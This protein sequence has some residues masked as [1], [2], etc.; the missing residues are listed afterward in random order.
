MTLHAPRARAVASQGATSR[1]A[2]LNGGPG[3][4]RDSGH[5]LGVLGG[6]A[7]LSLDAL[8]SV[9]YGPQAMIVILVL[10]GGSALRWTVPL[11]IVI[12]A[13]LVIL[14]FS[15]TQVIS[16]HPEGGGAYAVAKANLGRPA[17]LLAAA[18]LVVD[19]VLTVAVSLAVGAASLASVFPALA[20][21]LLL[22]SLVALVILTTVNMFGIAASAKL[23]IVPGALFVIS[24]L[25]VL[26]VAPFHSKPV[27]VIGTYPGPIVATKTVG[28]LLLLKAFANGC[29]A[30]TGVE[31]IANGVPA[32]RRPRVR[33]A[34]RTELALGVLLGVMLIGLAVLIRA[35][36][37]VPRGNV[38]ILAQLTAGTFG[39][40]AVFYVCNL[41]VALALGLAANT[42]F[43]GLP[44]LM[45]LLAKDNR[46]PH[47]FYLR[48][49]RPIYRY[50]I[51]TLAL[52]AALLLVVVDAQTERLIPLFTI[53][54]FIGFTISQL[55]LVRLWLSARPSRWR[56][57]GDQRPRGDTD[58]D[59]SR[60]GA[61]D[62]V[63]GRRVGCHD[64]DSAADRDVCA[65]GGVLRRGRLRTGAWEEPCSS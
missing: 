13:I 26:V 58:R 31:A 60:G 37:V 41:S 34:Q 46:L 3:G 10:A 55:G 49:E 64:R 24:I 14:V 42:S 33:A 44:V 51:V 38:T 45:E 65:H 6:L 21:H 48:A 57:G 54:V 2:G 16:A 17:S 62:Q 4:G 32:F 20:H 15:Y 53:G 47:V 50:G 22:V 8:T 30:I 59:R 9:A 5:E 23:L 52:A 1:D 25:A 35:H 11:T 43:G 39:K 7:A 40:G 27:A 63:P 29:T 12:A 28:L 18:S 56:K 19:Y 61:A 36:G